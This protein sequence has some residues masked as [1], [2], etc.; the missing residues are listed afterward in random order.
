M[1]IEL[2]RPLLEQIKDLAVRDSLQWIF[3]YI[4]ANDLLQ[5]RFEHFS[6]SINKAETAL[7]IPHNLGFVPLDIIPTQATGGSVNF[8]HEKFDNTHLVITTSA[9]TVLR[10][11][12]G[13]YDT[14]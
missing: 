2:R 8:L 3:D 9:P 11:F 1:S 13:R 12:A 6:L 14:R 10:F 5:G 7:R 4:T